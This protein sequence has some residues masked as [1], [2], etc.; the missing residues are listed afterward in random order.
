MCMYIICLPYTLYAAEV[1]SISWQSWKSLMTS[2]HN[3][4]SCPP[5]KKEGAKFATPVQSPMASSASE[6]PAVQRDPDAQHTHSLS[7]GILWAE[8]QPSGTSLSEQRLPHVFCKR[9]WLIYTVQ[10]FYL[11]ICWGSCCVPLRLRQWICVKFKVNQC[12]TCCAFTL[13][14]FRVKSCLLDRGATAVIANLK[15]KNWLILSRERRTCAHSLSL[16]GVLQ[17]QLQPAPGMLGDVHKNKEQ[18]LP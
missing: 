15:G 11:D 14:Q 3:S 16:K 18:P 17:E 8:T 12:N 2:E 6:S 7:Q 1:F 5:C 4:W 10:Q 9:V 13:G